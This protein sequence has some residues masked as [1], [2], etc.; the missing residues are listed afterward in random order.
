MKMKDPKNGWAN[1]QN[2][3]ANLPRK[4]LLELELEMVMLQSNIR[5][6]IKYKQVNGKYNQIKLIK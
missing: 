2:F 3:A 6:C 4:Q 1:S 5:P